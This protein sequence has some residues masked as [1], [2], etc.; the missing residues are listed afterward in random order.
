MFDR[1]YGVRNE[2]KNTLNV[3]LANNLHQHDQLHFQ[4]YFLKHVYI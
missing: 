4:V 3:L 1:E 2:N